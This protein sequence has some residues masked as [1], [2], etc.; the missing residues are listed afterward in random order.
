VSPSARLKPLAFVLG[1]FVLGGVAGGAAMRAYTLDELRP[2]IAPTD[3]VQSRVAAMRRNLDL[4]DDQARK[5]EEVLRSQQPERE[6]LNEPCK[7]ELDALRDR[8]D[9]RIDEVLSAEQ[10]VRYAE[11]RERWRSGS[12]RA[13]R[14]RSEAPRQ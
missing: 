1:V 13:E 8:T 9:A 11:Y 12:K 4:S 10:R 3:R 7:P 5:I 14:P 6:R 2:S